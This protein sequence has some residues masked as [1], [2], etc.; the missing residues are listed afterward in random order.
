MTR[1]LYEI[2]QEY[3]H[4]FDDI[5]NLLED[6]D[7]SNKDD[8]ISNSL[9]HIEQ[10]FDNKALNVAR[11]VANLEH[12]LHGV[13]E[14]AKRLQVR[15]KTTEN[16]IDRLREYLLTEMRNLDKKSIKSDEIVLTLRKNPDKVLIT[17][18]VSLPEKF[19][20]TVSEI[21]ID[22]KLIADTIKS[23]KSVEGAELT[24]SQRLEIK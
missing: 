21:K 15:A 22:K 10:E 17:D 7:I 16:K 11:Y 6:V 19:K 9:V 24:S 4:A 5:T 18:E 2:S 20:F 14:A 8:I 1:P 13:K 12:E 3:R 23:G